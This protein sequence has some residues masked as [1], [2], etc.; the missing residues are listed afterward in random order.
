MMLLGA[1]QSLKLNARKKV[2]LMRLDE[3]ERNRE[4]G[5]SGRV[6]TIGGVHFVLMILNTNLKTSCMH[7]LHCIALHAHSQGKA[8][9]RHH[10]DMAAGNKAC[11]ELFK[12]CFQPYFVDLSEILAAVG[13]D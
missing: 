8:A 5:A 3:V 6:E 4:C 1:V 12:L 10:M 9:E 11:S 13:V 7:A 2:N